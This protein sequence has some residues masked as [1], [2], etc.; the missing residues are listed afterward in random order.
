MAL[1]RST[2]QGL[3]PPNGYEGDDT[4]NDSSPIK[5]A[6]R[7]CAW[8]L[9]LSTGEEAETAIRRDEDKNQY[10]C[11]SQNDTHGC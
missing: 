8:V 2:P 9:E 11:P 6:K 10:Q 7:I 5:Q 4:G 3:R 1:S